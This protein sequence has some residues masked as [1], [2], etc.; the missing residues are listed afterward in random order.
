MVAERANAILKTTQQLNA[1]LEAEVALVAR[2]NEAML[3]QF[4]AKYCAY[5]NQIHAGTTQLLASG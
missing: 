2:P 1:R 3:T 5:L 4:P